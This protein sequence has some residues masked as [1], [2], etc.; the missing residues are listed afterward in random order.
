MRF[1]PLALVAASAVA[2]AH[3]SGAAS[4]YIQCPAARTP[5]ER[6]ICRNVS[7]IQLDAEMA[8]LY[9]V[10]TGLV[11]MG[12]RGAIRDEQAEWLRE[13]RACGTSVRC[14]TMHYRARVVELD[15]YLDRIRSQG[16]F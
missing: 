6:A 12:M 15:A 9:R 13:R 10:L 2:L 16:P 7:L 1:F 11:G 4:P 5:D 8:T 14:L 3:P